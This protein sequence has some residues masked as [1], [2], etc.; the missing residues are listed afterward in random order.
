M[1]YKDMKTKKVFIKSRLTP[2]DCSRLRTGAIVDITEEEYDAESGKSPIGAAVCKIFATVNRRDFENFKERC[3]VEGVNMD[4]ALS[5][6]VSQ[7]GSG[8][9]LQHVSH[10]ALKSFNYLEAQAKNKE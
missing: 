1:Y 9:V 10:K 4:E 6:L 2:E 5:L 8:A 3:R 7:Y